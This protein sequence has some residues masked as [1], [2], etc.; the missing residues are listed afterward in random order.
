VESVRWQRIQAL[1]ESAL[2]HPVDERRKWLQRAC[3]DD[4]SLVTEVESLL[5]ADEADDELAERV[6][7]SV[8]HELGA[9]RLESGQKVGAYTVDG[10]L[11][12]GG[13]G[14]VYRAR[15]SDRVYEQSVVIKVVAL[16]LSDELHERFRRERQILADL[17]HPYIARLLDGGTLP[18]GAPYLV[19][20]YV[21]G[22][23]IAT[24]C[25]RHQ[26]DLSARLALFARVCQA[27]QFA[28]AS[29]VI[30]RDIK[31]ANVLVDDSGTPRLLDFGIASLI[32]A[33]DD[34]ETRPRGNADNRLTGAYA[35]P[36]Q[37][38]GQPVNTA[39]DVYSLGALLYRLLTGHAPHFDT[40][41]TVAPPS[42]S[43]SCSGLA[44]AGRVIEADLDAVVSRA[45]AEDPDQRYT[46]PQALVDDLRRVQHLR[47]PRALPVGQLGRLS[48]SI[49]RNRLFSAA[50]ATSAI[51]VLAFLVSVTFLA[52]HLDQERDRALMAAETT[53]QVA[54]FAFALFEGADPEVSGDEIPSARELLDRGTVRIQEALIGQEGIRA[55]LL[56][57]MGKAYQ[58]LGQFEQA[59]DLMTEALVQVDTDDESLYWSLMVDLGD[60]ERTLGLRSVSQERLETVIEDLADRSDFPSQLASAYNNLGILAAEQERFERAE[61]LARQA[62]A[63]DLPASVSREELHGR[64]RHNLALAVGRQGRHDEAI[65]MLEEIIATKRRVLGQ[66]HPSIMRS[67]EVLA[68]NHRMRGDLDAAAAQFNELL[69][70]ARGIYGDPSTIGARLYNSLANVHHDRGDYARAESAYQRALSFHDARPEHSPLAHAQV[71]NNLA[72]LYEDRGSLAL[73]EP[74]FRRSLAMRRELAGDEDMLVI[75]ARGN[76]ARMLIKR[77]QLDE[78]ETL[79]DE[80]RAALAQ[81]FP[82]NQ[83]RQ[84]QLDWQYALLAAARG[85]TEHGR[86]QMQSVIV[87]IEA[88]YPDRSAMRSAAGLDAARLD[89][90]SGAFDQAA[91]RAEKALMMMRKIHSPDHP[92]RLRAKV[93]H[94]QALAAQGNR[95]DASVSVMAHW[96]VL[97]ERFS[98]DSPEISAASRLVVSE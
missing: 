55:R 95:A 72:S 38:R 16:P 57:H 66:P 70:Q 17:S 26:L 89:L 6:S 98:P 35:S 50:L 32:E 11:A 12:T 93:V 60:V 52:F 36:E 41:A 83:V 84:L 69:E 40:P 10:L 61:A 5:E 68:G 63:V 51:L 31:P 71:V 74:L 7:R 78:A 24:Y 65:E 9:V 33:G 34:S 25:D 14:S 49:R 56:Y 48:R 45:L 1:F 43:K 86:E 37:K 88:D 29:L 44:R 20:E 82:D 53:E 97:V 42:A 64:F 81:H 23:D 15:R 18:G 4:P 92:A 28:H 2:E 73:A 79:L 90:Q 47:P 22:R 59:R 76:L 19:M 67:M 96:P 91:D 8:E 85:D 30:H 77:H 94:A 21:Q 27:V 80:V 39:S 75:H 62:L 58:G 46:T 3:A 54:D 87:Q 13:M